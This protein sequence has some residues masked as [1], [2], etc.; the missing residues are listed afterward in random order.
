MGKS[1]ATYS[2]VCQHRARHHHPD[3]LAGQRGRPLHELRKLCRLRALPLQVD[4]RNSCQ[5]NTFVNESDAACEPATNTWSASPL[6]APPAAKQAEYGGK[7]LERDGTG[8]P[9]MQIQEACWRMQPTGKNER[10]ADCQHGSHA[11]PRGRALA[12]D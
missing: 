11:A 3:A 4:N 5:Q 8:T 7:G 12:S 2:I 9:R 10:A 6:C 1:R